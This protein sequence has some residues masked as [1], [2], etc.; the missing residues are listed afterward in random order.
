MWRGREREREREREVWIMWVLSTGVY[1]SDQTGGNCWLEEKTLTDLISTWAPFMIIA[2]M[3]SQRPCFA[4]QCN[5]VCCVCV[6]V[7]S[8]RRVCG[9]EIVV[10]QLMHTVM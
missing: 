4:A 6:C 3:I 7:S 9:R 8:K 1:I 10:F 2:E 5:A